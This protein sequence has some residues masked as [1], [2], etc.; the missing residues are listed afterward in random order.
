MKKSLYL[1]VL[2]IF[3]SI[4]FYHY[5]FS[6]GNDKNNS[7]DEGDRKPGTVQTASQKSAF[8][9]QIRNARTMED[10]FYADTVNLQIPEEQLIGSI[11]AIHIG[12]AGQIC[13]VDELKTRQILSFDRDG[14]FLKQ[15]GNIGKGPGEFMKPHQIVTNNQGEIIVSD[16]HLFR[17]SLFDSSGDFINSFPVKKNLEGTTVTPKDEIVIHDQDTRKFYPDSSTIFV[18]NRHGELLYQCGNTS[19]AYQ[20]LKNIPFFSIIGKKIAVDGDSLFEVDYAD[21]HIRKY[22]N[23]GKSKTEFGIKPDRWKSL[24]STNYKK[25]P[26]PQMVTQEIIQQIDQYLKNEFYKNSR[27][28]YIQTLRPGILMLTMVDDRS[29]DIRKDNYFC[30]YDTQGNLIR[31]GLTFGLTSHHFSTEWKDSFLSLLLP[32]S[33]AGLCIVQMEMPLDSVGYTRLIFLKMKAASI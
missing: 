32:V 5:F 14:H 15:I 22:W 33:P 9:Q 28:A 13:I 16:N 29:G 30:F 7:L 19:T 11:T 10:I 26:G 3:I 8:V 12:K 4:I 23:R 17:I 20:A 2:V 31:Q 25:L 24:L 18:Y 27:I 21:Y 1:F 6:I